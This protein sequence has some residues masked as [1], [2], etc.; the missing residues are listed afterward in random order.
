[1]GVPYRISECNSFGNGGAAGVSDSYASSLWVIDF[2][3]SAALGGSTGVNMHGG[4]NSAGYTPIADHSG[5]V[6]DVRPEYYGLL[7]FALAGPGTLLKTQLSAGTV[8][9]TAYAVRAE[10]GGLNL[11]FVNKDTI[12]NLTIAIET[13]QRI[14]RATMQTM[15]GPNLEATSGVTIQGAT[16]DKDGSFAPGSLD[17]LT[18]W[19]TQTTCFIPAL[20]A[21]LISIT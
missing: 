21:V 2:L 1:L 3:F 14:Q 9:V 12:H 6:I 17:P 15:T 4:G 10:S 16:V 5:A 13:N 7:L 19:G 8:D 20:S 11:I 18:F